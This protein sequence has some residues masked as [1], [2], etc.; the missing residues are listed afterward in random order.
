[1]Q[2]S[3]CSKGPH[4]EQVLISFCIILSAGIFLQA[5]SIK[6]MNDRFN[7]DTFGFEKKDINVVDN[8]QMD[9]IL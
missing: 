8:T 6:K 9:H 5:K 4:I 2:L 1:M 7:P 3:G